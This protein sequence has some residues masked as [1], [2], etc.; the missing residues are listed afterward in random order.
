MPNNEL[1]LRGLDDIFSDAENI[2]RVSEEKKIDFSTDIDYDDAIDTLKKNIYNANQLLEKIQHE[3]N[4]GNFSARLAEVAGT[5][6]SNITH[7]SKEI[8]SDENYE[9]SMEVRRAL[10]ELRDKEINLREAKMI[11]GPTS[12]GTTNVLIATREDILKSIEGK[13]LEQ[14]TIESQ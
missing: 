11:R 14:K 4:N 7:A 13:T 2:D 9:D 12:T 10:V 6:I 3:M 8:L 5:I 1:D